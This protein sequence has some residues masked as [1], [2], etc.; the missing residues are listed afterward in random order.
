MD[1]LNT[2]IIAV[3][4]LIV[5]VGGSVLAVINHRRIRSQCC[6]NSIVASID[7]EDTTPPG[8]KPPA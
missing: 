6:G 3:V 5:S 2:G 1:P 4:G 7:I 8:T